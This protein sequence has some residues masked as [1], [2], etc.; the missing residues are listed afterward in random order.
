MK[1]V[2]NYEHF[3]IGEIDEYKYYNFI[4]DGDNKIILVAL[5]EEEE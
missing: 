1:M 5:A 2:F 4:C 3:T